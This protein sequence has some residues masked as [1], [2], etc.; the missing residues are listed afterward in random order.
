MAHV[1]FE[2]SDLGHIPDIG[3]SRRCG[4]FPK[5]GVSFLGVPIKRIIVYS[6]LGSIL[7]P[8]YFGKLPW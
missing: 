6:I 8:P 5:L 4:G 3:G 7:G 2:A 1:R